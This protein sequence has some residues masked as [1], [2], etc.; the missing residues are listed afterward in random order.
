MNESRIFI[1]D[2]GGLVKFDKNSIWE[3]N[4]LTSDL[5]P[6]MYLVEN[7]PGQHF[8]LKRGLWGRAKFELIQAIAQVLFNAVAGKIKRYQ[9]YRQFLILR[10]AY[11]FDLQ[12]A[13]SLLLPELVLPTSFTK[14]ERILDGER[15]KIKEE[16][17][18]GKWDGE[19]WLIPD[20]AIASGTTITYLLRRG[21][22]YHRPKAVFIFTAAGSLEGIEKI[23]LVCRQHQVKLVPVFSQCIFQVSEHGTF[24]HLPLTDLPILNPGTITSRNFYTKALAIYQGKSMCSV[25]DIGAS[26]YE[27][28]EYLLDTLEE[29]KILEIDPLKEGWRWTE[30]LW[31]NEEFRQEIRSRKPGTY[32]YLQKF[33]GRG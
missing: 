8:L 7:E 14:L 5:P 30:E 3:I 21:F 9:S 31:Q 1:E 17:F 10:G 20:T 28:E 32:E 16:F 33:L 27:P 13:A 22:S 24:P 15:W 18:H 2:V 12:K 23:Y 25:G 11:P 29:M 6:I 4:R 19:A 26:L